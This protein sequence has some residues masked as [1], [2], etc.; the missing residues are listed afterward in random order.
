MRTRVCITID[1]EFSIG[2][3]FADP[4]RTPV[5]DP[6]VWCNVNGKSEGL[7]FMLETFR[8]YGVQA[9]FFVETVQRYHFAD[10]PMRP[11]VHRIRDEGHELQLHTHPCWSVFQHEDWRERMRG[12]RRQDD[13]RGR[14]VEDS[15]RLL[16]QGIE[17]FRDW[18]LPRPTA[19]RS[20]NLQ[21]DANL[22][23]ALAIAKIPYSSNVAH[24]I[25]NTGDPQFE[26]YS[27]VHAREGVLECPVLTFAD[28]NVAGR[29][30]L[31]SLTI[32]GTSFAETRRLLDAAHAAEIP[33]VV[34]LT[35]PFEYIQ[36][37]DVGFRHTRRHSL[38]QQRL[39]KL[40]A[41]LADHQDRF[42]ACGMAGAASAIAPSDR[43]VLLEGSLWQSLPRMAAQ[44]AYSK[45]GE[46][47][48]ARTQ[49]RAA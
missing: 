41:Y 46:W 23:K 4:S 43:N 2:G 31:K 26:L 12:L 3:A 8:Q 14:P 15:V 20:G 10:D 1:T 32:A 25:F 38:T 7:G 45:Y 48:L 36:K 42:D 16:E 37:H 18:G 5:A 39:R 22:Y 33:L 11:I 24:A 9:T 29:K 30:H 21:Y 35:H 28:W 6:V 40:C 49:G 13:F 34:V 44:V 27:G 19:F 47:E 17:T